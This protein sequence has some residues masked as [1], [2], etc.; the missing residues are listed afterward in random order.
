M[1]TF[2]KFEV[3]SEH[4]A[5][6]VHNLHADTLKFYLSNAAPNAAT[7][8]VKADLA[9]IAAGNGYPAG[10]VDVQN[11]VVRTGPVTTV[12]GVDVTITASGGSVP[13][14][15]YAILQNDS[16]ASPLKPLIGYYDYG[17]AITLL[18][19][20]TFDIAVGAALLTLT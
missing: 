12:T 17:S 3:W 18:D 6:G 19:G 20:D 15:R 1:A 11:A 10:G 13:P 2:V 14:F 5:K 8:Q 9:E 7:H 16:Q 4:Q